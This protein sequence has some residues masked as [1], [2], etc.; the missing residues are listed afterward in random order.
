MSPNTKNY[1]VTIPKGDNT[2]QKFDEIRGPVDRSFA[3]RQ[4]LQYIISQ[5]PNFLRR[6]LGLPEV[7]DAV[8]SPPTPEPT[9]ETP[10]V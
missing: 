2:M 8:P 3:I 6:L 7:L 9:I 1:S 5:D 4:V 10:V